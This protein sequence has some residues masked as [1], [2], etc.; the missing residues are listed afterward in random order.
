[1]PLTQPQ[2]F[3]VTAV[4]NSFGGNGA[5]ANNSADRVTGIGARVAQR[6]AL[7]ADDVIAIGVD[8]LPDN[9]LGTI[10][11]IGNDSLPDNQAINQIVI[12]HGSGGAIGAGLATGDNILIGHAT[13]PV[14][15]DLARNVV[16]GNAIATL[17]AQSTATNFVDNVVIGH[18]ALASLP[19]AVFG[20]L[21]LS[22]VIGAEAG[23]NLNPTGGGASGN[24]LIGRRAGQGAAAVA[25]TPL[26]NTI[27]GEQA[28]L[29]I[30][31][32]SSNVIIGRLAGQDLDSGIEN[33]FVGTNSGENIRA[34][35]RNV[36]I[37]MQAG[38][39]FNTT[40]SSENVLVGAGTGFGRQGGNNIII[41]RDAQLGPNGTGD[42][43]I[44][45]GGRAN[46]PSFAGSRNMTDNLLIETVELGSRKTF[47]L[48]FAAP[49]NASF[50]LGNNNVGS[51]VGTAED[52]AALVGA[53][54][55]NILKL[56]D[57]G[58]AAATNPVAGGYFYVLAGALHW[59]G[60]AGT[61]T[62]VAVA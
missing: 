27:I 17:Y 49:G 37:G 13:F 56:V 55:T 59:V 34:A 58:P 47:M 43:N 9:L 28:G 33:T 26:N 41:G 25:V 23:L 52:L 29:R 61:D 16:I 35:N 18:R 20:T 19:D 45:L 39:A 21:S 11:V 57:G 6:N 40:A 3:F 44:I 50:I 46:T 2:N 54:A 30:R 12:G 32:C 42:N 8:T 1:M 7:G 10:I 51:G 15:E 5:G 62:V 31:N 48:G 36:M 24:V 53:G 60:S 4:D 22:V 38:F 14:G